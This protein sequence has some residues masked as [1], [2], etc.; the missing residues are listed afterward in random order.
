M[1][2]LG[3]MCLA[4]HFNIIE[5]WKVNVGYRDTYYAEKYEIISNVLC[6]EFL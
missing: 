6:L 4:S 5:S 2:T 3:I 1:E